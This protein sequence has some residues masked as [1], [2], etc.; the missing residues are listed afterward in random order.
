LLNT[1]TMGFARGLL[2]LTFGAHENAAGEPAAL[3]T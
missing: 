2:D 3:S 1:R